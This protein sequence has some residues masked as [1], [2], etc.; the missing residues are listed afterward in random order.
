MCVFMCVCQGDHTATLVT[1]RLLLSRVSISVWV[2]AV[3]QFVAIGHS[4]LVP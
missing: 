4:V 1:F 3:V 2:E